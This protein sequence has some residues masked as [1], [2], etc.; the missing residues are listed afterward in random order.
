MDVLRQEKSAEYEEQFQ[1]KRE[2]HDRAVA[3][4]D[5]EHLNNLNRTDLTHEETSQALRA[6][7][8]TK[9]AQ[10]RRG[11]ACHVMVWCGVVW[12]DAAW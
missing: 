12:H 10:V 2:Q 11:M 5:A 7:E 9:H 4:A 1:L 3:Q 6:E 8:N